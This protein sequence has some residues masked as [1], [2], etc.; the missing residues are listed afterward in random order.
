[1]FL[2]F[3]KKLF[4]FVWLDLLLRI[5]LCPSLI[6][7]SLPQVVNEL[8]FHENTGL[9]MAI[10]ASRTCHRSVH[11]AL[12]S[13]SPQVLQTMLAARKL[14]NM[15]SL[16]LGYTYSLS[17]AAIADLINGHGE[18]LIGLMLNGKPKLAEQF[19]L[20]AIPRLPN[21]RSSFCYL[22]LALY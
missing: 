16:D 19:W 4:M 17:E 10:T 12:P 5:C 2:A 7:T 11:H 13:I 9:V 18:Q 15:R 14:D 20:V 6:S 1:M 3:R 22:F 8:W 21:I